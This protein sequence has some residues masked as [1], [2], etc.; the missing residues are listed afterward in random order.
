MARNGIT[1]A[2]ASIFFIAP[3][4]ALAMKVLDATPNRTLSR[5]AK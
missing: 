2:F 1:A 3:S 5:P 4:W